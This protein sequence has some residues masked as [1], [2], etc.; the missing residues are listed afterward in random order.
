MVSSELHAEYHTLDIFAAHRSTSQKLRIALYNRRT[1]PRLTLKSLPFCLSCPRRR[2]WTF[3]LASKKVPLQRCGKAA[4]WKSRGPTSVLVT[5]LKS[6]FLVSRRASCFGAT[7]AAVYG[8]SYVSG[9]QNSPMAFRT[10]KKSQATICSQCL[11][12][13]SFQV[14]LR[15]R[16]GAAQCHTVSESW[17]KYSVPAR[18]LDWP[19]LLGCAGG[20]SPG[21]PLPSE[22]RAPQ[23]LQLFAVVRAYG[24]RCHRISLRLA[25]G[26]RPTRF[27]A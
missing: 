22:Q 26:A 9:P 11:V 3:I 7:R 14:V 4:P 19:V 15:L 6:T 25:S 24:T 21:F 17:Q 20:P 18:G 13:N 1:F 5:V 27:Q 8:P 23:L 2:C 12:R 10:V 16:C